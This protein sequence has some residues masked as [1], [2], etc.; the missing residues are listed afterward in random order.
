MRRKGYYDLSAPNPDEHT[1]SVEH[2]LQRS[3]EEANRVIDVLL[4][5]IIN[6]KSTIPLDSSRRV[7]ESRICEAEKNTPIGLS[8]GESDILKCYIAWKF[9]RGDRRFE[10]ETSALATLKEEASMQLGQEAV[11]ALD[12]D[13]LRRYARDCS[14]RASGEGP[15]SHLRGIFSQKGLLVSTAARRSITPLVAGD[16]PVLKAIPEGLHLLDDR[17]EISMPISKDV[18]LSIYGP[19]GVHFNPSLSNNDVRH[20]NEGTFF[21]CSELACSSKQVLKSLIRAYGKNRLYMQN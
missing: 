3:E 13:W 8:D 21:Q 14:N 19:P 10:S 11:D 6:W 17:S 12:P 16:D 9:M 20:I 7:L 4:E 5:Q 18:V 1:G 2:S 15:S